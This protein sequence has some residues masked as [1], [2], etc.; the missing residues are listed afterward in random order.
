MD[1]FNVSEQP[2][3]DHWLPPTSSFSNGPK[4]KTGKLLMERFK[5]GICVWASRK[6]IRYIPTKKPWG[7]KQ[8]KAEALNGSQTVSSQ[9]PSRPLQ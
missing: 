9:P 1:L 4:Y 6:V 3:V 7:R 5:K 8:E 2:E